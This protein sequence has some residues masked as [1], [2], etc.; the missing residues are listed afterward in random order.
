M[1]RADPST[2]QSIVQLT[3][4]RENS[5]V[6]TGGDAPR[7]HSAG[8]L[9]LP[10]SRR[11]S[12]AHL[13]GEC[14]RGARTNQLEIRVPGCSAAGVGSRLERRGLALELLSATL[15]SNVLIVYATGEGQ[16]AK[17]ARHIAATLNGAG[18][19]TELLD[20]AS[21]RT[22]LDLERFQVVVVGGPVHAGGYPR[23]L[24]R[25]VREHRRLLESVRAVFFSVS[26]AVLS[27][28]SDGRAQTLQVVDA[29]VKRT[30]WRPERV[31][32]FAG[33]LPYTKY[34]FVTRFIMRRIV[35]KEGGDVDTSRDY[36]YTDWSA[37]ERFARGLVEADAAD[38]SAGAA[39]SSVG[40]DGSAGARGAVSGY[41][42]S[43]PAAK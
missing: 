28:T 22:P 41:G 33:A 2:A 17:I 10:P 1:C 26:L 39:R 43:A 6:R 4:V 14:A 3:L 35:A 37:V 23:S 15:M 32:L 42:A 7:S 25:F 8:T 20:A 21:H 38:R 30:G 31:E 11:R 19:T 18:H 34:N 40:V 29:F 5:P 27:R 9:P 24:V 36:E 13:R 12:C 16:T